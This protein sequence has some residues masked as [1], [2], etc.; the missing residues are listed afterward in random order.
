[1]LLTDLLSLLPYRTHGHQPRGGTSPISH[2]ENALQPDL[3]VAFF[4][5]TKIPNFQITLARV[6][7]TEN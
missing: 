3:M 7:L 2:S 1:M 6:K 4:F 5:S